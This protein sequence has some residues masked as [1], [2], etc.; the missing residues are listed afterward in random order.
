M[1]S[2][3]TNKKTR[4]KLVAM[5]RNTRIDMAMAG[6]LGFFALN[7]TLIAA[8]GVISSSMATRS[9]GFVNEINT[10]QLNQITRADALLN[11]ARVNLEAAAAQF[12]AE[13]RM[14]GERELETAE[15]A[16]VEAEERFAIFAESLTD[17]EQLADLVAE[18]TRDFTTIVDLA[19]EQSA[20]LTD[21]FLE[22]FGFIRAELAPAS[23]SFQSN[24]GV[25]VEAAEQL[26]A[27]NNR[28]YRDQTTRMLIIGLVSMVLSFGFIGVMY[29]ALRTIVIEPLRLGVDHLNHIADADLSRKVPQMGKNEIG[30][31][32]EAM[33]RMSS[34]LG[35]VVAQVRAGSDSI[36]VGAREIAAGNADLSS[37]TEQ[38]ASSLEETATSMEQLTV[39]VR[40]N[41]ENAQ[42]ASSMAN[43]AS[44]TASRGGEVVNEVIGTMRDISDSSQKI[45]DITGLIDSIAFQTNILALNASV[46]AARAGEQGRGFAVVAGE[47]RNLAGR[48]SDAARE[49]RELIENSVK[50]VQTGSKLVEDA[51][52]TME[53]VVQAVKRVTDIMDEISSASREQ[54][55]GIE[56]VSQA[57]GQMDEVTQQNAALVQEAAAAAMSLEEQASNLERLVAI[58]NLGDDAQR[59]VDADADKSV[60]KRGAAAKPVGGTRRNG[61][62][63]TNN[64][65]GKKYAPSPT[66][67]PEWVEF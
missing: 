28:G 14:L 5:L 6:V 33:A 42:Q 45:T 43:E 44:A 24:I 20:A 23:T 52:K 48:S 62:S 63:S 57:V 22:D 9:M 34:S 66:E 32:F 2:T 11:A 30:Q 10:N 46:E 50:Q 56:Q 36:H 16:L 59:R 58:F 31:L 67:E 3:V 37:R 35:S 39:T 26:V 38:Q 18:I 51:G 29:L 64:S 17:N 47:V 60:Q 8:L 61:A 41:A 49:I 40:Q 27:D 12:G 1:K 25:F 65:S 7:L 15:G 54:S 13:Q 21:G 53:E 19:R 4:H 55:S